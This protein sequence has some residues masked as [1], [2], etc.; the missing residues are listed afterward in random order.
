MDYS[1]LLGIHDVDRGE[2]EEEEEDE[3]SVCEEED[4]QESDVS[5]LASASLS[6]SPEG[7]AG[8]VLARKTVTPAEFDP[9]VD[10][11]GIQSAAGDFFVFM[12]E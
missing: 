5:M 10:V 1:L 12:D 11:Y 2:R 3:D 9:C 7:G 8:S 6:T 4:E